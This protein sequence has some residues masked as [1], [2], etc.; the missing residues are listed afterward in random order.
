MTIKEQ[1]LELRAKGFSYN[2]I[3]QKLNCSK[4]TIAYHCGIGQKD[5]HAARTRDKRN[6]ISKYIQEYKSKHKCAD[7]KEDY[8]YWIMEFDHLGNKDFTISHFRTKGYTIA[9]VK[10]EIKKCEV[11]CSNCHRNRTFNRNLKTGGDVGL[12]FCDYEG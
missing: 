11:V 9:Q 4:G 2:E 5:K 10:K 12:E 6:K 3:K 1:I 7:C 8:P